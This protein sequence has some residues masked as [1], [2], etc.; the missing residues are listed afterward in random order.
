MAKGNIICVDDE[1]QVLAA[2]KKDLVSLET[3]YEIS[4]CETAAEAWEL[5]EEFANADEQTDLIIC[6]HIMPGENGVQFLTRMFEDLRFRKVKK[7]LLTGLATHQET[8]QAINEAHIDLYM[9][10]PWDAEE[11]LNKIKK[12]F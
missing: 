7:I 11:L 9:E 8:I 3:D 6:D 10:K 5:L 12:L 2:L 4:E 1:R